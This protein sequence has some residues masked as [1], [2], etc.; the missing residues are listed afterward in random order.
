VRTGLSVRVIK[1][2]LASGMKYLM[3]FVVSADRSETVGIEFTIR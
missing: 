3:N 2:T 1:I